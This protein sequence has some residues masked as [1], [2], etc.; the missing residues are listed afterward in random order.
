MISDYYDFFIFLGGVLIIGGIIY[1][2]FRHSLQNIFISEEEM[3][4]LKVAGQVSTHEIS[5]LKISKNMNKF[6]L[7]KIGSQASLLS[8]IL[9]AIII[10]GFLF[11]QFLMWRMD[12]SGIISK[13]LNISITFTKK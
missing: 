7:P 3:S 10:G 6:F 11:N 1:F 9:L 8:K 13:L 5:L 4:K 12:S 2:L